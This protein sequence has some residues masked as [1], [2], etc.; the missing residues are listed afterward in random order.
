[1]LLETGLIVLFLALILEY[2]DS[3]LGMGYGTT[4]TPVLLVMGFEP[5]QIVPAVL[6]SELTAGFMAAGM[7][8]SV[9]NVDFRKH[10]NHLKIAL[11]LGLLSALGAI[12]A[13]LAALNL[14]QFYVKLYIGILVALMGLI[15]LLKRNRTAFSWKKIAS[16]GIVAS[17]NKGISGGGYGPLVVTGQM[18]SGMNGKNAVAITSL[19]EAFTCLVAVVIYLVSPY[20]ID[21]SL[22]PF[23]V[24]GAFLSAPLSAHTVKRI[25]EDRL[26]VY[27]GSATLLLG[28]F[29]LAKA[30]GFL[31]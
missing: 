5:L 30:L 3:T 28:I 15:I 18:L 31:S 16:L 10:S 14:P 22:A 25:R 21:W 19:A 26:T 7:H 2:V 20:Q 4:L 6:L 13:V 29:T 11:L 8:H 17:F 27:V 9:G 23:L 1:M 12:F 24:V